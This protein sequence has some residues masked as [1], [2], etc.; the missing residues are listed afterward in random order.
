MLSKAKAY[1]YLFFSFFLIFLKLIPIGIE[2]QPLIALI[3][4]LLILMHGE[5]DFTL[6]KRDVFFVYILM[7]FI[8]LYFFIT[9]LFNHWF[10]A[11]VDLL[12]YLVG[13]LIYLALRRFPHKVSIKTV[14]LVVLILSSVAL[15]ILFLPSVAH[16]VFYFI[17]SRSE[18]LS[19]NDFRGISIL[20]P[21]PSYFSVFEIILLIEIEHK[22]SELDLSIKDRK[23]LKILK[24][25]VIILT[26]LTKSVLGIFIAIIFIFPSFSIRKGLVTFIAVSIA[27]FLGFMLY[28]NLFPDSRLSQVIATL[29]FLLSG[30]DFNLLDLIFIQESSGGARIILNFF[31]FASVIQHP[32]GSGLG[33]FPSM[34]KGYGDYYNLDLASHDVL[35]IS[36]HIKFYPQTYLANLVND[37]GL[38][39]FILVPILFINNKSDNKNFSSKRS[40]CLFLMIFFQSQITSPAFWYVMAVYK[41]NNSYIFPFQNLL[42][43]KKLKGV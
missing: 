15:F 32:F 43:K 11:F 14:T 31:G 1:N 17:V 34:L 26:F 9:L 19:G 4:A 27:L 22:L 7:F 35:S 10:S 36:D 37:M 6:I 8:V 13:P 41:N 39:A 18:N 29:I 21:E 12:K 28:I 40:L 38:F 25:V 16:L 2:T 33:S 30:N 24:V 5:H 3:F 23:H 42:F 20:T